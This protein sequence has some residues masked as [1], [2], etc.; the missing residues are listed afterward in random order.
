MPRDRLS[1]FSYSSIFFCE[2]FITIQSSDLAASGSVQRQCKELQDLQIGGIPVAITSEGLLSRSS[3]RLQFLKAPPASWPCGSPSAILLPPNRLPFQGAMPHCPFPPERSFWA[4]WRCPGFLSTPWS[5]LIRIDRCFCFLCK[6]GFLRQN[7]MRD[8]WFC[9]LF[10]QFDIGISVGSAVSFC[11]NAV[12]HLLK[13]FFCLIFIGFKQQAPHTN[14]IPAKNACY[15]FSFLSFPFLIWISILWLFEL[16]GC[17]VVQ[18]FGPL[19][20]GKICM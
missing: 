2:S 17:P 3:I 18:F 13:R 5:K 11:R 16:D 10:G 14:R 1:T 8:R 6:S 15:N 20:T 19:F 9:L 12:P 7:D 4:I